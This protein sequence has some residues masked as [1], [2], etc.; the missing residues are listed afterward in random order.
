L[1]WQ[2]FILT[3]RTFFL[4]YEIPQLFPDL[5]AFRI[6]FK[7]IPNHEDL[8]KADA[9]HGQDYQNAKQRHARI[10][11]LRQVAVSRFKA[12]QKVLQLTGLCDVTTDQVN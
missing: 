2:D 9:A 12:S 4:L 3:A 5:P 10:I 7:E 1:I 8:Q 6:R 11:Q